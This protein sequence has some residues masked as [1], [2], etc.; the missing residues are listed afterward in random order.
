MS[1][2]PVA[3][4]SRRMHPAHAPLITTLA[5]CAVALVAREGRPHPVSLAPPA[6]A[7]EGVA[8]L[9][10]TVSA[11]GGVVVADATV[12][13]TELHREVRVGEAGTFRVE[14]DDAGV[15]VAFS[16]LRLATRAADGTFG[17]S[18]D[19]ENGTVLGPI[20]RQCRPAGTSV[21]ATV[22]PNETPPPVPPTTPGE[23]DVAWS[24]PFCSQYAR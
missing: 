22:D 15:R 14:E 3:R 13:V 6:G 1:L 2:V 17:E 7:V 8:V 23:L 5:L 21:P 11:P 18:I 4:R 12:E 20:E 16:G 24:S 9:E 19:S 10:G